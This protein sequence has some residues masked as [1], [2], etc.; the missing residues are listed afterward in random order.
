MIS[1]AA[2]KKVSGA[3]AIVRDFG[4]LLLEGLVLAAFGET[5]VSEF[6]FVVAPLPI[7]GGTGTVCPLAII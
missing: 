1:F 4:V 6:L 5:G 3:P 2:E 7:E